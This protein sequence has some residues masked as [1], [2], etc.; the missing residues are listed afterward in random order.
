MQTSSDQE[1]AAEWA[2]HNQPESAGART[3]RPRCCGDAGGLTK[4]G[5]PC[6]SFLNLSASGKCLMHDG[7]RAAERAAM[8]SA[9]GAAAKV[10]R[11]RGRAA[12]PATVPPSPKNLEDATKYFAWLVDAGARGAMDA[13]TVHECSFALKG[14]QSAL[15][16]RDL[17]R[18]IQK[19]RAE[20][21]A[22]RKELGAKRE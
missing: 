7:A 12:D 6:R 1:R 21:A 4:T 17:L 14:F 3:T 2:E 18:E 8:R 20:L 5:A 19:L 10:A 16:K 13:R 11:S 9:G 22:A 15:E